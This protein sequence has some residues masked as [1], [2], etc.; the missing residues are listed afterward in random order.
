[1]CACAL[2]S[3]AESDYQLEVNKRGVQD[4]FADILYNQ[5]VRSSGDETNKRKEEEEESEEEEEEEEEKEGREQQEEEEREAEVA[6]ST[7]KMA[8]VKS[9]RFSRS[10]DSF[11]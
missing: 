3:R 11:R 10:S 1:L 7:R 5:D 9:S 6:A 4:L 8:L 2:Q